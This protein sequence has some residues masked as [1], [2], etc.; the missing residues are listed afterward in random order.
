MCQPPHE[1]TAPL[2]QTQE[3]WGQAGAPQPCSPALT[4]S[5]HSPGT[6]ALPPPPAAAWRVSPSPEKA[7]AGA[8]GDRGCVSAG[9]GACSVG[10]PGSAATRPHAAEITCGS[11]GPGDKT[12]GSNVLL[13]GAQARLPLEEPRHGQG[14]GHAA[15]DTGNGRSGGT[16]GWGCLGPRQADFGC[17]ES[18]LVACWELGE[19]LLDS[20]VQRDGA[21]RA[22]PGSAWL[23]VGGWW[24]RGAGSG[25]PE[26]PPAMLAGAPG[27]GQG[28]AVR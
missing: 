6:W 1:R 12:K 7:A 24:L 9:M 17:Q 5:C 13:A 22:T 4:R 3:P 14:V 19:R 16:A 25:V 18:E 28:P 23:P 2:P 20:P 26:Q 15:G 11:K 10:A 21:G 8:G 27:R